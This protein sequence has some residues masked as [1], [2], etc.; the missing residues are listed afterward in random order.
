MDKRLILVLVACVLDHLDLKFTEI[1]ALSNYLIIFLL[2]I[3]I[4]LS[5]K[6][7][8]VIFKTKAAGNKWKI[9]GNIFYILCCLFVIIGL[10]IE[11]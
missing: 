10:I 4:I 9:V 6:N 8:A 11:I 3:V 2:A 1:K 7:L 5:A